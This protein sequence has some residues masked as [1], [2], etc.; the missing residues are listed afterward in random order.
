MPPTLLLAALLSLPLNDVGAVS[1]TNGQST[2]VA[3]TNELGD[4]PVARRVFIRLIDSPFDRRAVAL[5]NG[6]APH[7]ATNGSDY[8]VG[9]SVRATRFTSFIADSSVIRLVSAEG[10][11]GARKVLSRSVLGGATAVAWNGTHWIVA[12]SLNQGTE[13]VSRVVWLDRALNVT[14][15]IDTGKGSVHALRQIGDRWWAFSAT[16]ALEIRSDGTIGQR[17]ATDPL[18]D[19]FFLTNAP[20]PLV[21]V[22]HGLDIDAIPFDPDSGFG[23]RRPFL[24]SAKLLDVEASEDGSLLL[25]TPHGTTQYDAAFVDAT[26]E[27]RAYSPVFFTP[28]PQSPY[29]TLGTSV[30]GPLFFFSP[31]LGESWATGGIDLFAY[32]LRS[33]VPLDP[34]SGERVSE[35]AAPPE[36]RRAARH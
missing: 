11:P 25:F 33:L 6:F 22:Q 13:L 5:G 17:F 24:A 35:V 36:R 34:T 2:L 32:P 3:W 4:N 1:L 28:E 27:I 14:A 16:E 21:L 7:L 18:G 30:N 10:V 23:A 9:W 12:Y 8:L 26:G 31:A 15:G 19:A 20:Q 29:A